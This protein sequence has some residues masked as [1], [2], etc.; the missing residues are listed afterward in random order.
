MF[1]YF[2]PVLFL[3]MAC[4]NGHKADF[5]VQTE[6]QMIDTLHYR[7]EVVKTWLDKMSINEMQERK[8]IIEHNIEYIQGQYVAR[9]MKLEQERALL[10]DEYK[11]YSKM[12]KR[13]M[14]SFKPI[15]M[16]T[17]EL[18]FQLKTL[19]E[20]AHS[21]DYKKETFLV[22]YEKEKK[23]VL[24]LLDFANMVQRPVIDTDMA[25]DRAQKKIEEWA[26]ELKKNE[27]DGVEGKA[28]E[29]DD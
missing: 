1:K 22:Y 7:L 16:E 8:D 5:E 14:D 4:N 24:K 10:V 19:K 26:E 3:L 15:V 27:V 9:G 12:Y 28:H 23:D 18:L 21:K 29:E 13:A 6:L 11:S 25:F 2:I 17:E 20:S